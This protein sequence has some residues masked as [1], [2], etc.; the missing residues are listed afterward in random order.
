MGNGAKASLKAAFFDKGTQAV[1]Q[2]VTIL[3]VPEP[4][5]FSPLT[6]IG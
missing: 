4:Y 6:P 1:R 5:L 2:A 3:I